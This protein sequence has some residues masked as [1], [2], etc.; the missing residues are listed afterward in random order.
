VGVPALVVDERPLAGG[1]LDLVGAQGAALCA[2]G[3]RRELE[4]VERVSRVTT[5][6]PRDAAEELKNLPAV[7]DE[8]EDEE[9]SAAEL[10]GAN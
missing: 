3:L 1:V 7:E 4:D 5:G 9:S 6:A 10:T 8:D 2:R